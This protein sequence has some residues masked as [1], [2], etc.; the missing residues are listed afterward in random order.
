[1]VGTVGVISTRKGSDLFVEAARLVGERESGVEFRMVGAPTD[2]LEVDWASDVLDHARSLGIA[3][4]PRADVDARL[5]EWDVFVLP[6]RRDPF[7]ISML[8]AMGSG[9]PVVGT[10]V[11]GIR[12]QI[13]PEIGILTPPEDPRALADAIVALHRDPGRRSE[14]GEAARRRALTHFSLE[15]Q[16]AGLDE[17]YQA[18]LEG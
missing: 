5:A 14:L 2:A 18:A 16:A 7:P 3:H 6:S 15:R 13:T 17:A 11:D 4:E 10:A 12:E 8:E 1:V 9:L